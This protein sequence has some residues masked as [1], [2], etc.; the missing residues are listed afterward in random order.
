MHD[1]EWTPDSTP[2]DH[3]APHLRDSRPRASARMRVLI[4]IAVLAAA[5]GGGDSVE[6]TPPGPANGP[7]MAAAVIP[8]QTVIEGVTVTVD[9]AGAFSDPDG[10]ALTYAARSSN[11]GVAAATISGSELSLT[12]VSPGAAAITVT[13]TDPGGLSAS[14]TFAVEVTAVTPT[15]LTV[16]P[17]TATL[18][19]VGRT[20]QLSAEV[21]DQLGRP[22]PGVSVTWSSGETSVA[23]VDASGRVTAVANG[24][25]TITATSGN[26]SGT[27]LVHVD[28]IASSVDVS[29]AADTLTAL[30]DT[31]RL[32]AEAV[33]ANGHAVADAEF[34]WSSTDGSVVTVDADGLATAVDNGS[35]DI[36]A[37]SDGAS[38]SAS[39]VVA[40]RTAA[41]EISPPMATLTPSD[42]LRLTATAAD[43]NGHAVAGATFAWTSSDT[44][45]ASVDSTGLVEALAE[46]MAT[47]TA[48]SGGAEGATDITVSA[49]PP[50][51]DLTGY[52]GLESIIGAATGGVELTR[53]TVSG[54]LELDQ[55]APVGT[56]AVGRY[57]VTVTTPASVITDQ[58]TYTVHGDGR[59]EQAGQ[60]SGEGSYAVAGDTL[61]IIIA[62]PATASSTTVWVKAAAPPG[63][64]R[65]LVVE[66]EDRCSTYDPED[67]RH[68]DA[69]AVEIV[70]AMDDRIYAPYTGIYY[71]GL[72]DV[73]VDHI[74]SK[75]EVHDSGGCTWGRTQRR[76][77]ARDLA[78][79]TLASPTLDR[80]VKA[81]NDAAEW[82]PDFNRC[83]YAGAVVA[84]RRKY[85]LTVDE[86]ER[87]ALEAVLSECTST[88]MVFAPESW[89]IEPMTLGDESGWQVVS[90]H[91]PDLGGLGIVSQVAV[92][93]TATYAS[94]DFAFISGGA[95]LEG[96]AGFNARHTTL[97]PARWLVAPLRP[98]DQIGMHQFPPWGVWTARI[99][100]E[101]R[102]D[103]LVALSLENQEVSIE[104]PLPGGATTAIY[105]G[106]TEAQDRIFDVLQR[107]NG[108]PADIPA[109]LSGL[110][111]DPTAIR[112]RP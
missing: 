97:V 13:A 52:Y 66:P 100:G 62:E 39:L 6:P 112:G 7:P 86:A 20:V 9:V 81:G 35:A 37:T 19:A 47:I 61:T 102:V 84:V 8:D 75:T 92:F 42:T 49:P 53:P 106:G 108:G 60:V 69:L 2:R 11:E 88:E 63:T 36:S 98:V 31:L 71:G 14:L 79:L 87:D 30:G 10:D 3:L 16:T 48:A 12:G 82:L 56:S 107:C 54:T 58:G 96:G 18:T 32:T 68:P 76:A 1:R 45:I 21:L 103:F 89:T 110:S 50:P 22:V 105:R 91:E 104:W 38:G 17:G 24:E 55:R 85:E 5:C 29:P 43:A 4:G 99:D 41:V 94:V 65:G 78:N 109:L 34:M 59:W 25:A 33:D 40:Q 83:W 15:R 27:A 44:A 70:A 51:P 73:S 57:G 77:F 64:W 111:H 67:Y 101:Q 46:G 90:A 80:G 93:C 28:Q 74:V 95:R 72:L 23:T 26:A